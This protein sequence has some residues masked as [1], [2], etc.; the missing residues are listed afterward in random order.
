MSGWRKFCS[1]CKKL[2]KQ[3]RSS[4]A[5]TVYSGA[6]LK[7]IWENPMSSTRRVSGELSFSQSSEVHHLHNLGVWSN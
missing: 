5:K 4:R 3:A 7:P 2:D 6:G 1:S